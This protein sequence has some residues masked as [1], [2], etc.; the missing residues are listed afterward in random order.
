MKQ[1]I[2]EA[3]KLTKQDT[4]N[5]VIWDN[6]CAVLQCKNKQIDIN[7][8]LSQ[9]GEIVL[10][11]IMASKSSHRQSLRDMMITPETMVN[12]AIV[13]NKYI[14][15]AFEDVKDELKQKGGSDA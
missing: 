9:D 6:G 7:P 14:S 13:F 8:Y 1:Q 15:E 10:Q 2:L 5:V 4:C 3:I 11:V 12:L